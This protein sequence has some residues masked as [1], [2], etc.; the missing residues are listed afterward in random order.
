MTVQ[1]Q[2]VL[3]VITKALSIRHQESKL[4]CTRLVRIN[5]QRVEVAIYYACDFCNG[6]V[7]NNWAGKFNT[8]HEI[9]AE[10]FKAAPFCPCAL[11]EQVAA[12]PHMEAVFHG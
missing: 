3:Q 2:D 1:T 6:A 9:S 8:V 4:P 7:S 11:A 12:A 5:G 10:Q